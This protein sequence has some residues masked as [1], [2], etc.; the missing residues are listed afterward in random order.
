MEQMAVGTA[1]WFQL[2]RELLFPTVTTDLLG[3]RFLLQAR[4]YWR[5]GD[6]RLVRD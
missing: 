4:E 6:K 3:A 1:F 2:K 5:N